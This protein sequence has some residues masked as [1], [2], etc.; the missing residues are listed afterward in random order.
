LLP[1]IIEK[2]E[3]ADPTGPKLSSQYMTIMEVGGAY[4]H[5]F[6]DLLDFLELRSLV[7][8]DI[9]SVVTP[10]GA[11]CPVCQGT[12]TSNVCL[13][14]WFAE[15]EDY[16]PAVLLA[17]GDDEKVRNVKRIAFQRPETKDGP[18]G[19]TFEDAFILANRKVFGIEAGDSDQQEREAWKLVGKIKKSEFAL[20]YAI[21]ETEWS[22][23]GYI[24]DGLAWLAAGEPPAIDAGMA[25]V[26]DAAAAAPSPGQN[27]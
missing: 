2:M 21:D 1:V 22:A 19:R 17:K 7:I 23:P 26:A 12:A 9:D 24:L 11:A 5:L 16:S 13:K 27:G 14:T 20:K 25:M 18:C 6:F 8:T 15:E 4:A 10:G 3:S